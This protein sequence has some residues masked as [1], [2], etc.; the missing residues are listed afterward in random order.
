MN[1]S[2]EAKECVDKIEKTS[3]AA[4]LTL[5]WLALKV[6]TRLSHRRRGNE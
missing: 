6:G 5:G 4:V 3:H 2:K 1:V